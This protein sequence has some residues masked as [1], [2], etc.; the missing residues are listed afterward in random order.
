MVVLLQL[1]IIEFAINQISLERVK[2]NSDVAS[3]WLSG[4]IP[5]I[6]LACDYFCQKFHLYRTKLMAHWFCVAN[7]QVI[8]L[9]ASDIAGK[10]TRRRVKFLE[11][12]TKI[13]LK[14]R[15]TA[16]ALLATMYPST[17][18]VGIF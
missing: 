5:R 2:V 17:S 7:L 16:N 11:S 13:R 8:S 15:L 9:D 4:L 10:S 1:L 18:T 6:S 14:K 3:K 12:S